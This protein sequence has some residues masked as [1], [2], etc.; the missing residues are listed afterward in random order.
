MIHNVHERHLAA[1]PERVGALLET[2]ATAEDRLWP[3]DLWF[4]MELDQP[5]GVGARGGHVDV[6]YSVTEHVPG[7]RVVFT[8]EAP[9][10][11]EGTHA[12]E[13]VEHLDGGT[14]LRHE[15]HARPRRSMH[16]A[17]PLVVRWIHDAVAE[18]ALDRAEEAS[19]VGPAKR[20][21]W[22]WYVRLLRRLAAS[23]AR[24]AIQRVAVPAGTSALAGLPRPDFADA[25]AVTLPAGASHDV[26][27]WHRALV[28]AGTPSWVTGLVQVRAV[29]A[30]AMRLRTAGVMRDSS[31]FTVI[32]ATPDVVV[33][34]EDDR[35]LDFRVVIA[36]DHASEDPRLVLTTVV[37]RHNALGR[38]Y[39]A[40]V[41]PFH[42][43]V[44][45]AVLRRAVRQA[46]TAER[47]VA[48]SA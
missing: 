22:S 38:A 32:S 3:A 29:L 48:V 37:Q 33:A 13:V 40:V 30:R 47:A 34:G 17:W 23:R 16:L 27:D 5:L 18:D 6:R 8:F 4:P 19:G 26:R 41:R 10:Q 45:P 2:L 15:L 24:S 11:L 12:F 43:Q 21:T 14:V 7:R 1:A 39:F 25:F 20:A 46:P 28:A 42:R 36:L 44:V 9:T 31:P 35:H